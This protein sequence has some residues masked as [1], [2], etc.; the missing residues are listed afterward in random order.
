M[1]SF[2]EDVRDTTVALVETAQD[3]V[4][5]IL[6]FIKE[7]WPLLIFLLALLI[8][9]VA[10]W[11]P[12]P[13]K[14][15]M[16]ASGSVGGSYEQLASKYA[17]YFAKR[18][19]TLEL[20][21][22]SGSQENIQRL[23]DRKDPIQ[24]A[25]VQGGSL[26]NKTVPG[27]ESLGNVDYEP[28]WFFYKGALF[29]K[30]GRLDRSKVPKARIAVGPEGSG[31]H[32]Q[33]MNILRINQ[34]QNHPFLFPL[35][36]DEAVAA[37]KK[38]E[39][40]VVIMVDG[41]RSKNVQALLNDPDVR[42]FNFIR[43]AAYT[44]NIDYLEELTVPMGAFNLAL[45]LPPEDTKIIS[46]VTN[47]LIDDRMHPAIQFLFMSAAQEI[48][49]KESFF[50]KRGEFPSFKNSEF[51]ESPIAQQFHQR[52]LPILMDFL[53]FWIAE[54]IH[55]MFFTLV[56][57]FAIAY[58]VVLSLPG[59][60]LRRVQSK[61]NR[62]YGQLKFFENELLLSYDPEKLPEY[63]TKL[64]EMERKALALKIP[65]RAAS[66]FYTL[67]TSIDYVRNAL[68]R[69]DHLALGSDYPA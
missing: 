34:L 67:R 68:N 64:A 65:K 52:G 13:P 69:G 44:K 35:H 10:Y 56:P 55:R 26:H 21:A 41:L 50:A 39:V 19:I 62:I 12:P 30:D 6:G 31:T 2:K 37:L 1:G 14:R 46:T 23:I 33:A 9:L 40:D 61:L 16:M 49:G 47:L 29:T 38:G 24:A 53:P 57:F 7:T 42:L 18:G 27:V 63:M 8:A 36:N 58:P 15:V 66:D 43:A 59:Y 17:D 22:T 48:N 25:F 32:V 54:F 60:R 28:I 5:D 20:V 3:Q 51:P 11:N 4:R 45:N